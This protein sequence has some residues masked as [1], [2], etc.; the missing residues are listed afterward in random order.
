MRGGAC[1][2]LN[3][4]HFGYVERVTLSV[5]GGSLAVGK[6]VRLPGV[7]AGGQARSYGCPAAG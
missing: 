5:N 1:C 4:A 6:L 2:M 3:G 7:M